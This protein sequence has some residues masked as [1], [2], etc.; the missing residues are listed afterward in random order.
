MVT[1]SCLVIFN[2][3]FDEKLIQNVTNIERASKTASKRKTVIT[4]S[5]ISLFLPTYCCYL[6]TIKAFPSLPRLFISNRANV[7]KLKRK[8]TYEQTTLEYR[9]NDT[10]FHNS[11]PTSY[12][13][14]VDCE[15][16]MVLNRFS[17]Y[18]RLI[19]CTVFKYNSRLCS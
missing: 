8:Y 11:S 9:I 10:H 14:F 5:I 19:V 3:Y 15:L 18:P 7:S 16:R 4:R 12:L 13:V 17:R 2:T 1:A 6:S